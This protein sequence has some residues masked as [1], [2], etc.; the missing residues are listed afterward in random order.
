MFGW[1]IVWSFIKNNYQIVI[2][3]LMIAFILGY[4]GYLKVDRNHWK[5]VAQ[6][7]QLVI[8]QAN[9]REAALQRGNAAITDKYKSALVAIETQASQISKLTQEKIKNDQELKSLRISLHAL[10]LFNATKV[11]PATTVAGTKQGD[12]GKTAGTTTIETGG[13]YN[14]ITIPLSEV[15]QQVAKNDEAHW[16]CVKVVEEWQHFWQDYKANYEGVMN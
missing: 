13:T 10:Q 6:E 11:D 5:K 8:N 14:G 3:G 12:D 1:G 2:L 16:K 4:I 15:F 7:L 9:E